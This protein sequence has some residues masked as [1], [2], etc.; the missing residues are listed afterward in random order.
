MT[1]LAEANGGQHQTLTSALA[2]RGGAKALEF[3]ATAFGA[4]EEMR[5]SGPHG[6]IIHAKMR[7]GASLFFVADED[8]AIPNGFRSPQTVGQT[9]FA[10]YL[11]V[12][13]ADEAFARAVRAGA[14][15]L[16]P[17]QDQHWGDREGLVRDPFGHLW[18]IAAR[19]A[20]TGSC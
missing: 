1:Q 13:N 10:F 2:V 12:A 3:Y 7:I 6:K 5:V 16:M 9:T 19:C 20:V 17:V 8:P 4:Q 14:E 15:P 11:Y 18:A